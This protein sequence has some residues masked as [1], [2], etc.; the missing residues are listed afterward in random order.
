MLPRVSHHLEGD[1]WEVLDWQ[2]ELG[3][4]SEDGTEDGKDRYKGYF[5]V[6][7]IP[8]VA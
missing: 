3:K 2:I 4:R 8:M 7:H 6:K 1:C 5:V